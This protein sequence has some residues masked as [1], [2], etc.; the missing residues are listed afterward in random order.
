MGNMGVFE[1]FFNQLLN[2]SSLAGMNSG[3]S[4]PYMGQQ[5]GKGEIN[6][7]KYMTGYNQMNSPNQLQKEKK[8]QADAAWDKQFAI[9]QG[10]QSYHDQFQPPMSMEGL[11]GMTRA[12]SPPQQP[13]RNDMPIGFGARYIQ[14]LLGG[15]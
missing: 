14:Q 3:N 13:F 9:G 10:L 12:F 5:V 11:A 6:A 1:E 15:G 7:Q 2:Q 8:G 4:T